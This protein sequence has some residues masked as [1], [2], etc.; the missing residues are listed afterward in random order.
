M[1]VFIS[2]TFV[3]DDQE[4]ALTL[5]KI[6][7]EENIDG[8]LAEKKKEY[9]LLIRDKIRT[10]IENSDHVVAILT[11]KARESASVNQEIGY[12]L[13]E[14]IKPI[15]MIEENA[16][17]GVL[18]HGIEPEEFTREKFKQHCIN[19]RNFIQEKGSRK[20]GESENIDWLISNVYTDVYNK[21]M[22]FN[23]KSSNLEEIPPNVWKELEP[24]AKLKTEPEIADMLKEYDL[25]LEKLK[26][27]FS[28]ITD[29]FT[30]NTRRLGEILFPAFEKTGMIKDDK[31]IIL[32]E[33]TSQESRH[34]IEAF[35]II[36]FDDSID[37]SKELY[38][39]LVKFSRDSNNGMVQHLEYWMQHFPEIFE[40]IHELLPK[41]CEN[42][43]IQV[44]HKDLINQ[45]EY[46]QGI[47]RKI[48]DKLEN[49]FTTAIG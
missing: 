32:N 5:Q 8:Y 45:R 30:I 24:I 17:E 14:G 20:K 1:K 27:M 39:K 21:L 35:K 10:E 4:L 2:H 18:T 22:R 19:V 43:Q 16:K 49:R 37:N 7:A 34:W 11:N 23:E 48:V 9:D 29:G 28:T 13:R 47:I 42:L 15:I 36:L 6:L 25:E 46:L 3:E 12:A 44:T 38:N 41:L 33:T 26:V 31:M 40:R